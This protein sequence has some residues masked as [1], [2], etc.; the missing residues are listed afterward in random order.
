MGLKMI[1]FE[2]GP[3]WIYSVC[4][5]SN[6]SLD[7]STYWQVFLGLVSKM[8]RIERSVV[9]P[10]DSLPRRKLEI[11]WVRIYLYQS[12]NEKTANTVRTLI[13]WM[14]ID[15]QVNTIDRMMT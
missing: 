14:T 4:G 15:N 5:L 3:F 6:K 13:H 9:V 2:F 11:D 8:V 7:E 12:S 1:D 10:C